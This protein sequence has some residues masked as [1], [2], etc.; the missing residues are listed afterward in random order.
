MKELVILLGLHILSDIILQPRWMAKRKSEHFGILA[1]HVM[2]IYMVTMPYLAYLFGFVEGVRAAFFNAAIHAVIDGSIWNL[3][4]FI[5]RR[6]DV[7]L[8]K[9]WED[10]LFYT[11]IVTDQ[12]L[13]VATFAFILDYYEK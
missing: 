7:S 5:H 4:K 1:V 8:F 11:F 3:Y 9:Y 6:K 2:I 13:H 10:K 12:M